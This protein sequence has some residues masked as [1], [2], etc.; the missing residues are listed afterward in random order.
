M[1][2]FGTC[3]LFECSRC[4][5]QPEAC[6]H[7]PES[8]RWRVTPWPESAAAGGAAAVAGTA[9]GTSVHRD[10]RW[11]RQWARRRIWWAALELLLITI[12]GVP[13]KRRISFSSALKGTFRMATTHPGRLNLSGIW[14]AGTGTGEACLL[15]LRLLGERELLLRGGSGRAKGLKCCLTGALELL[16]LFSSFSNDCCRS[17]RSGG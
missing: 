14:E 15:W 1:R 11:R 3:H 9:A 12:A 4:L 10:S 6:F 2:Y 5:Q 16:L 13:K 17:R 7:L 8:H